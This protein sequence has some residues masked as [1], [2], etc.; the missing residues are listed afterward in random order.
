MRKK[1]HPTQKLMYT[2]TAV[3]SFKVPSTHTVAPQAKT[4]ATTYIYTYK[5]CSRYIVRDA[6]AIYYYCRSTDVRV[7]SAECTA[8]EN[9]PNNTVSSSA[10]F[11]YCVWYYATCMVLC[12]YTCMH[13]CCC[14]CI[15]RRLRTIKAH[16]VFSEASRFKSS[17]LIVS[18]KML[19]KML[20]DE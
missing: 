1:V 3:A 6:R 17:I 10:R 18:E 15:W 4:T 2:F 8:Q 7:T 14:C 9:R 20:P 5:R 12:H 16:P 11:F 13:C 19:L